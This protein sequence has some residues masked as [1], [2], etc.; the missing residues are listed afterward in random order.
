MDQAELAAKTVYPTTPKHSYVSVRS[1]ATDAERQIAT[2]EMPRTWPRIRPKSVLICA[3]GYHWSPTSWNKVAD[4]LLYTQKQG[5]Y[6]GLQEIQ[7]RCMDPYDALGTMRNEA[8]MQAEGEGFEYL[9]YVDND[10]Q[11]QPDCLSRLLSWHMPIVAP[12]VLEPGTGKQ[13]SGPPVA[14]NSGL[15]PGKWAVLSMLLFH[16]NVFKPF[17][18]HFWS[19]AIGAD[20]GFHFQRLWTQTGHIPYLDTNTQLVVSGVPLYPLALNRYSWEDRQQ[21]WKDKIAKLNAPPDRRPIDAFG[22]GVVDGDYMPF[23]PN[24]PAQAAPVTVVSGSIVKQIEPASWG[25]A[26]VIVD[27]T[28]K[29]VARYGW[30]H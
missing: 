9:L 19:D 3:M 21:V 5:T 8:I 14:A 24:A 13:L 29:E 25:A 12:Y 17:M 4:M 20:E 30:G 2:N 18:G 28:A 1:Y 11:P 15:H 6:V 22:P 26:P 10:I 27:A 23:A 7:D 16:V